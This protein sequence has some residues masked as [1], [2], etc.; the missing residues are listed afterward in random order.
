MFEEVLLE[1]NPFWD[2]KLDVN[3]DLVI[4]NKLKIISSN[5]NLKQILVITGI[6]RS[7]KSTLLKE[8]LNELINIRKISSKNI[9]YLNLESPYFEKYKNDPKYLD[10]IYKEFIELNNLS[11]K[12][13]K[14]ILLDEIQFFKN[15]QVFVKSRYE[16]ENIKFIIT[17]SNSWL[18]SQEF[19][20]L[21][22][23]RALSFE[24]FP[25]DFKEY[26]LYKKILF[27]N[28]KNLIKNKLKIIKKFNYYLFEGGFPEVVINKNKLVN[29]EI[30]ANYYKNIL[31]LD[32]VPRFNIKDTDNLEKL[33]NYLMTNVTS[34]YSYNKLS[35]Y[36]K[37]SDKTIKEYITSLQKTYL[38]FELN[39]FDYSFKKQINYA[40]KLYVI[41]N[42]ILNSISFK[43][44]K[45]Y[46]KLYENLVFVELNRRFEKI[47]YYVTKNNY[48]IDFLVFEKNKVKQ[49]IQVCYDL[50]NINTYERE[51]RSLV[52]ASKELKCNDLLILTNNVE[53]QEIIKNK[54][55]YFV[56]LWKWLLE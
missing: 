27:T 19:S 49:L 21:L 32:V 30:L 41:D 15:W 43:F 18:L 7:G 31:F 47:Y 48:E 10:I 42:G 36:L 3:E 45:D 51:T 35:K 52:E 37:F 24:I 40:K 5:L 9:L 23:G 55:I 38:L 14:Y 11:L 28:N 20:T 53:K 1:Q 6:R 2:K 25:F 8:I 29:K 34:S 12:S 33:A 26:L 56:P 54:K 50:T 39:R 16:S 46:G 13:K 17:G 4:R 44:S 22:S